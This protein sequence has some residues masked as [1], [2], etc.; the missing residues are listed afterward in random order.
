MKQLFSGLWEKIRTDPLL[1]LLVVVFGLLLVLALAV[2]L[3]ESIEV[4]IS[5][6]FGV[7][8][9]EG[10]SKKY[11]VLKSL[12]IVMGGIILVIQ[13]RI[14]N[15]R[16]KAMENAAEEQAKAN[17]NTERG[18]RQERLKNAIEHLGHSSESVRIGGTHELRLLILAAEEPEFRQTVRDILTAHIRRTT[19]EEGE[20]K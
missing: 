19:S 2:M 14:A 13:A 16:A 12:V 9:E 18:Q 11:K 8:D 17:Q 20:Q 5:Q 7:K 15:K 3:S 1:S 10:V 4:G 6:L